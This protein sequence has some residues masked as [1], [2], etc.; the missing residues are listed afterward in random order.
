MEK[1]CSFFKCTHLFYLYGFEM[2]T[3]V[4]TEVAVGWANDCIR[5]LSI[6]T[7]TMIVSLGRPDASSICSIRMSCRN[8]KTLVLSWGFETDSKNSWSCGSISS[9]AVLIFWTIFSTSGLIWL[10]SSVINLTNY[11]SKTYISSF[12]AVPISPFMT[13][14]RKKAFVQFS[15]VFSLYT[16]LPNQRIM[17]PNFLLF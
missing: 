4:C 6:I 16:S 5:V 1:C 10:R 2:R 13:R 9:N 3:S 17:R 12:L 14:E 7:I 11:S 8:L 15:I